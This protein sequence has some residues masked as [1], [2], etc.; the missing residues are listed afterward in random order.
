MPHSVLFHLHEKV[1]K[2]PYPQRKISRGLNCSEIFEPQTLRTGVTRK[3]MNILSKQEGLIEKKK[4]GGGGRLFQ[5]NTYTYT[6]TQIP[7][8]S[9]RER[10]VIIPTPFSFLFFFFHFCIL[11]CNFE[12]QSHIE[13]ATAILPSK[14]RRRFTNRFLQT[15]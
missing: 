4:W 6:Y 10:E 12:I 9:E 8:S 14:K 13:P 15:K 7:R 1:S 3:H 5:R 2:S 11:I